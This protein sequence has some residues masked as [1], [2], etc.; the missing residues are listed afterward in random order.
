M[1]QSA[2]RLNLAGARETSVFATLQ[3]HCIG[4]GTDIR[5]PTKKTGPLAAGR[6]LDQGMTPDLEGVLNKVRTG[7][8]DKIADAVDPFDRRRMFAP[9]RRVPVSIVPQLCFV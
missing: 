6:S 4:D 8:T 7:Q 1:K 9:G 3:K 2:L 5:I